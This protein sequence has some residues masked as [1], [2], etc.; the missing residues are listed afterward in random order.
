[1]RKNNDDLHKQKLLASKMQPQLK[2]TTDRR[3]EPNDERHHGTPNFRKWE[4]GRENNQRREEE[5]GSSLNGVLNGN[6]H[7][8][9]RP[10]TKIVPLVYPNSWGQSPLTI[11]KLAEAKCG[12]N[13]TTQREKDQKNVTKVKNYDEKTE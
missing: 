13:L 3:S 2:P 1:M 8:A 7:P 10:E 4:Q 6:V 9:T 11:V 12:S 5:H